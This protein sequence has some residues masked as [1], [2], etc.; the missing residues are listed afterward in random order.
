MTAIAWR[1]LSGV[2]EFGGPRPDPGRAVP[3]GYGV[4]HGIFPQP[5][6][7]PSK[8][9]YQ[10]KLLNVFIENRS[11]M[12]NLTEKRKR[13]ANVPQENGKKVIRK[14]SIKHNSSTPD[15]EYVVWKSKGIHRGT[16]IVIEKQRS[17][18]GALYKNRHR[19]QKLARL[20]DFP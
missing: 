4:I 10:L 15:R 1:S 11:R 17:S 6:G 3:F 7:R 9:G 2:V 8:D 16:P 13:G 18:G 20:Q 5:L 14:Q 12:I 19:M